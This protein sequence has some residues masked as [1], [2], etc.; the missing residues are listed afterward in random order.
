MPKLLIVEKL[1]SIKETTTKEFVVDDLYKK[2]G[3]KVAT[4]FAL[5][6]TFVDP[7][8]ASLSIELYGKTTG[9]AG[10]ENKYDF[11]PP[12]DN[13]LLFGSCIMVGKRGDKV[14]DITKSGWEK[15]YEAL[16]GGFEDIGSDDDEDELLEAMEEA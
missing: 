1:G 10:Q 11:P 5:L 6:H 7:K 9:R 15:T 14:V 12:M 2:A 4:G 16:F 8:D 13:T 3:F